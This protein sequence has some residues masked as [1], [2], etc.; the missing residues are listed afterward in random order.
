MFD[1]RNLLQRSNCLHVEFLQMEAIHGTMD[2]QLSGCLRG[3]LYAVVYMLGGVCLSISSVTAQDSTAVSISGPD[4]VLEGESLVFQVRLENELDAE[5]V[6]PYTIGVSASQSEKPLLWTDNSGCREDCALTF[7]AGSDSK[8]II[9]NTKQSLGTNAARI[10]VTLDVSSSTEG[11]AGGFSTAGSEAA[12]GSVLDEQDW[13]VLRNKTVYANRITLVFSL[14]ISAWFT[15]TLLLEIASK[16]GYARWGQ[17]FTSITPSTLATA[18]ILGTFFGI[19]IGLFDF[20]PDN[21][22]ES[23]PNLLD[24]LTVA[25]STSIV[26]IGFAVLFRFVRAVPSKKESAGEVSPSDIHATLV[27]I[28]EFAHETTK[29]SSEHTAALVDMRNDAQES[30]KSSTRQL[31]EI[32]AAISSEGDSSLL[33]QMQKLRTDAKDNHAEMIDAFQKFSAH[34]VE[35]NQK[36]VIE[37]LKEVI[38]DFNLNLSEQFGEN[39]KELNSAVH[40][41]VEWQNNYREHLEHLEQRLK[42]ITEAMEFSKDALKSVQESA[43]QIPVAISQL[44]PVLSGVESKINVLNDQMKAIAELRDK[45]VEAFPVI[46]ENLEKLTAGLATSVQRTLGQAEDILADSRKKHDELQIGYT[47]ILKGVDDSRK[48]FAEELEGTLAKLS[49]QSAVAFERQQK[50]VEEMADNASTVAKEM[51]SNIESSVETILQQ[52]KDIM[53][54][55]RKGHDEF[56][57]SYIGILEGIDTSRKEFASELD[58]TMMKLAEQ[59]K[60]AFEQQSKLVEGLAENANNAAKDVLQKL[61]SS[62]EATLQ[63]ANDA[64]EQGRSGHDELQRSYGGILEGVDDSRKKFALELENAMTN[65]NEQTTVAHERQQKLIDEIAGRVDDSV[66]EFLRRYQERMDQQFEQF[67]GAMQEELKRVLE[68]MAKPLTSITEKFVEDYDRIGQLLSRLREL[69]RRIGGSL[70]Q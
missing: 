14:L 28:R 64:L 21:I 18:G 37:A 45:A 51:L 43:E 38:R 55:G 2:K 15:V 48:I 40:Q 42:L 70:G 66:R 3:I 27:D 56:H 47:G 57:Q 67:D 30:I 68:A 36:A 34:M 7:P 16:F 26:G 61:T 46:E 59:S 29:A 49:E 39:F 8:E 17:G 25:F 35:N 10:K 11:E 50:F 33:T 60:E 20:D 54:D 69:E 13:I 58:K 1:H 12:I 41:L 19:L 24:G 22:S 31:S 5:L 52:A 53:D 44:E 9:I 23:V 32:R 62:V 4:E 63:Q 6:V 65:L